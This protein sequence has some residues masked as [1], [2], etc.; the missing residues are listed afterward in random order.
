MPRV[1]SAAWCHGVRETPGQT[2]NHT[3][4]AKVLSGPDKLR[5]APQSQLA[6]ERR[7]RGT[8]GRERLVRHSPPGPPHTLCA[9]SAPI[10]RQVSKAETSHS[11]RGRRPWSHGDSHHPRPAPAT[12]DSL[13]LARG[14]PQALLPLPPAPVTR[15]LAAAVHL[16]ALDVPR[17]HGRT[18]CPFGPG[19][20]CSASCPQVHP[21][22][23]GSWNLIPS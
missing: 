16:P 17:E 22:R 19:A 8:W 14:K 2:A 10:C 13:V 18:C 12:P 11:P 21:R 9:A 3:L 5:L 23:R 7:P 15:R 20:F 6:S 4:E 1:P